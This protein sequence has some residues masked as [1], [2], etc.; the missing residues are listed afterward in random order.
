MTTKQQERET[1]AKIEKILQGVDPESYIGAAFAGCID[2]AKS[3]IDND[4]LESWP[5]RCERLSNSRDELSKSRSKAY[6][7]MDEQEKRWSKQFEK[8]A[9]EKKQLDA[10]LKASIKKQLPADL[11]RDLW[12]AISDMEADATAAILATSGTL[13]QLADCP[14]DIAVKHGL[15]A[16]AKATGHRDKAA[17]LLAR[18][19]KYE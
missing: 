6:D 12:L 19:E 17:D 16:L 18:L 11:Y 15:S 10:D 14:N 9:E 5:E 2:L 13:A 1:L 7:D 4:F 3:N 8:L